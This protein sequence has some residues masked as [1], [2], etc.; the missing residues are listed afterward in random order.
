T[1]NGT[2]FGAVQGTGSISFNGVN[3]LVGSWTDSR[4]VA[5][6]APGT[7]TGPV[8]VTISGIASSLASFTVTGSPSISTLSPASGASG[9]SVTIV[10]SNFGTI[11]GSSIVTFNGASAL[12]TTWSNTSIAV[13]VPSGATSGNV[14]VTVGSATSN[15]ATFS[16]V[17][18][19]GISYVNS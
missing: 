3:A 19:T 7:T 17:D 1:I 5:T 8:V 14:V 12:V 2:N 15:G 6:V 18:A 11:Q 13:R 9:S 4:I 16:V 10:G